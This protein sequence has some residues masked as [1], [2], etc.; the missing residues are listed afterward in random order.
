MSSHFGRLKNKRACTKILVLSAAACR[1]LMQRC[2][3]FQG[4]CSLLTAQFATT[5]WPSVLETA[6]WLTH[7]GRYCGG[8]QTFWTR[9]PC[10]WR[11]LSGVCCSQT[12][13]HGSRRYHIPLWCMQDSAAEVPGLPGHARCA[14]GGRMGAGAAGARRD[15]LVSRGRSPIRRPNLATQDAALAAAAVLCAGGI[16]GHQVHQGAG[17]HS[18]L[19]CLGSR[20]TVQNRASARTQGPYMTVQC[21]GGVPGHPVH[22]AS[23]C[24]SLLRYLNV[25]WALDRMRSSPRRAAVS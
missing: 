7:A 13:M 10:F 16:P 3:E 15:G 25:L 14:G 2:L 5:L 20:E 6:V 8:T 21:A 24:N 12:C 4:T 19:G 23:D 18:V 1:T 11:W 9:A 17:C 22:Q